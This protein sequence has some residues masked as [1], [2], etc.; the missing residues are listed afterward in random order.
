MMDLEVTKW[1][2]N[3]RVDVNAFI[4][5]VRTPNEWHGGV[6]PEARLL[7]IM[8]GYRF[9]ETVGQMDRNKNYYVYCRSGARSSQA[10]RYMKKIGL[11]CYNLS[12]GIISWD[13]Q[14]EQPIESNIL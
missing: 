13:E 1:K 9:A 8:E 11:T 5:D 4:L 12:G 10:C 7:N 2:E 3:L 6:I 14:T